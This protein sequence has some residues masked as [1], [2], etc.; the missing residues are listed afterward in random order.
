[1]Y[2]IIALKTKSED[3]IAQFEAVTSTARSLAELSRDETQ[4]VV[5]LYLR[6]LRCP[7]KRHLRTP[8]HRNGYSVKTCQI[9]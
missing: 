9:G 6:M 3:G 7:F 4:I 2:L 5:A 1:M 8:N